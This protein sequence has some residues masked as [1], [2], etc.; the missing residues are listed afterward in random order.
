MMVDCALRHYRTG[1]CVAFVRKKRVKGWEY[2]QLV[3][4]RRVDGKPRQRVLLHLGNHPT[5]DH[6]LEGWPEEIERLRALAR[7]EREK[8]QEGSGTGSVYRDALKRAASAEKR[9]GQ[10]EANLKK[11]RELRESGVA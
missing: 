6:A 3:E 8:A 9:A 10:L 2:H 11:A 4:S 5:V 7:E 1:A